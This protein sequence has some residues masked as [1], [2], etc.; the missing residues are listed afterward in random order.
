MLGSGASRA[1]LLPR[2]WKRRLLLLGAG[3]ADGTKPPI[4]TAQGWKPPSSGHPGASPGVHTHSTGMH[5]HTGM[6]PPVCICA[7]AC[8]CTTTTA[9]H[10]S[11]HT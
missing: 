7:H 1:P 3:A 4:G 6:H 2:A 10:R 9:A 5:A 8:T 11:I